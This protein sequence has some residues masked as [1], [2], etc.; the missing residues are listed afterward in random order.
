YLIDPVN[1]SSRLGL[2][3]PHRLFGDSIGRSAVRSTIVYPNGQMC[4]SE[5]YPLS[6]VNLSVSPAVVFAGKTQLPRATNTNCPG[7]LI[8]KDDGNGAPSGVNP[9]NK[10]I[11]IAHITRNADLISLLLRLT[12]RSPAPV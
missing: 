10:R 6:H 4:R 8:R 2:G 9:H 5:I 11:V 3:N 1:C 12:L 7:P